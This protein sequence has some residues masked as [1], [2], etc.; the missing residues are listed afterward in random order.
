MEI[1]VGNYAGLRIKV[2]SVADE[3]RFCIVGK[4]CW[5]PN[6]LIY[7][8]GQREKF[9]LSEFLDVIES[10]PDELQ[11][12]LCQ[13][14]LHLLELEEQQQAE[15]SKFNESKELSMRKEDV[16]KHMVGNID[17]TSQESISLTLKHK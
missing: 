14:E 6:D 7:K 16:S 9:K 5:A 15:E 2:R 3:L 13:S 8:K 1:D 4:N 10:F 17:T 12:K 11:D